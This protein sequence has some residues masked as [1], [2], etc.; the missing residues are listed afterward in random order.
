MSNISDIGSSISIFENQEGNELELA[1]MGFMTGLIDQLKAKLVEYD[2]NTTRL[3]LSQSIAP[4][5]DTESATLDIG[6]EMN[7][8]W[9]Y[10]NFGVNGTEINRGAPT[11]GTAPTSDRSFKQSILDWIPARGL[12]LPPHISTYESFAYAIM[13]NIRKKGK[14]AKP[15]VDDVLNQNLE[16]QLQ[17]IIEEILGQAIE[18]KI[19]AK[20]Q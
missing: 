12:Q 8:Y 7:D 10:V 16:A 9:K 18:I 3:S 17:P 13:T 2:S 14:E 4:T 6:I 5:I 1:I 19:T 11:W 15:F 20:W